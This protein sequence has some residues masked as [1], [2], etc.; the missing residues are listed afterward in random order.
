LTQLIRS[1]EIN[2]EKECRLG[3]T[4]R[5][6]RKDQPGSSVFMGY[7]SDQSLSFAVRFDY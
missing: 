5:I 2:Y 6:F 4:L 3:E 1:L 7:K